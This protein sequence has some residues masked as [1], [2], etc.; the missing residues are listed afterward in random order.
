MAYMQVGSLTGHSGSMI[1][2]SEYMMAP[3]DRT[4]SHRS[5]AEGK[6]TSEFSSAAFPRE[7]KG[8]PFRQGKVNIAR[9]WLYNWARFVE[10][11][12]QTIK[13]G[14]LKFG[15]ISD[16]CCNVCMEKFDQ[17]GKTMK[18]FIARQSHP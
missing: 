15:Q 16:V 18:I 4:G 10:E 13:K 8:F 7:G 2:G 5:E 17:T 9:F 1:R 3:D 12:S 6:W 11:L 14:I